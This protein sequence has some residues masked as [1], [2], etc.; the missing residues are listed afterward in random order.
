MACIGHTSQLTCVPHASSVVLQRSLGLYWAGVQGLEAG[1]AKYKLVGVVEH[2][3]RHLASG[4]Y[5]AYVQRGLQSPSALQRC[6]STSGRNAAQSPPRELGAEPGAAA[7]AS[8]LDSWDDITSALLS[9]PTKGGSPDSAPGMLPVDGEADS[10]AAA[11]PDGLVQQHHPCSSSTAPADTDN[12]PPGST[13]SFQEGRESSC[14]GAAGD[15]EEHCQWYHV[16]DSH[17]HAVARERVLACEAYILLYMR[18]V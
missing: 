18:A 1:G 12:G 4:H 7:S 8:A 9:S 13:Q 6:N 2:S 3:G 10:E 11:S 16:S 5:W 14:Q 17:V 15:T